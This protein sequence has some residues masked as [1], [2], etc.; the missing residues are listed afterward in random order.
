[1]R[2]L[3]I[4]AALMLLVPAVSQAKSLE[5]LLA[6]KGVITKAEARGS[7]HHGSAK[8]YWNEGTRVEFPDNG[9][10]TNIATVIRPRYEFTDGDGD[11]GIGNTS[12]FSIANARLQINGTAL[13]NEF[14]YDLL[15]DFTNDTDADGSASPEVLDATISW[16]PCD[17]AYL[18]MG[19]FRT[20]ISRQFNT[21]VQELQFADRSLVSDFFDLGRQN[22]L[23]G[24]WSLMDGQL[25][26][27]A[28]IFNGGSVVGTTAEG[29]NQGGNDTS[30]TAVLNARF[31]VMGDIDPYSEGDVEHT[32]DAGLS[33]GVAY[34]YADDTRDDIGDDVETS[35][36]NADFIFKSSGLSLAGEFYYADAES[37]QTMAVDFSPVGFYVQ[38]GYF[39]MPR[40]MEIALRYGYLDYDLDGAGTIDTTSQ[41]S[42]SLNYYWWKH[43]LKAQIGYE[44]QRDDANAGGTDVDTNRWI[45]QLTSWF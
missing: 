7:M 25:E 1:M 33:V 27:S 10:T 30:H 37:D 12:S 15:V 14:S 4:L 36:V 42:A 13:N 8:M 29:I 34:A 6:D 3:T 32:E 43:H 22:G 11:V 31:N 21:Y 23:Q 35:I 17:D 44:F 9:F 28:A 24:G 5:E 40:E 19:Q 18:K 45:L 39:V 26:L 20:G 2:K 41:A 38:G 16:M